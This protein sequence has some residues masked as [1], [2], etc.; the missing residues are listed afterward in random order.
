MTDHLTLAVLDRNGIITNIFVVPAGA[1]V[2]PSNW[3]KGDASGVAPK[4]CSL[5][6]AP[7]GAVIGA[8]VVDGVVQR[9]EVPPTEAELLSYSADKRWRTEQ[10]GTRHGDIDVPT[11]DR[12]KLLLM[13]AAMSMADT[14]KAPYVTAAGSVTLTGAQFKALYGAVTAHVHNCFAA[15]ALVDAGITAGT[16]TSYAAVDTAWVAAMTKVAA[17]PQA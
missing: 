6:V 2:T 5:L 17:P 14:D 4:G 10:A 12:S 13:G 7:A 15:Q 9:V 1:L 8:R 3:S 16:T 11:S